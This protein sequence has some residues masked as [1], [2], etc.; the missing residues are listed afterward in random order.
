MMSESFQI[1]TR[2]QDFEAD[3]HR[4]IREFRILRLTFIESQS[5]T[6]PPCLQFPIAITN[7]IP[8]PYPNQK[9][10]TPILPYITPHLSLSYQTLLY[11]QITIRI[12][13]ADS[14]ADSK[15]QVRI[16]NRQLVAGCRFEK[17]LLLFLGCR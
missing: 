2:D 10:I 17:H 12:P 13:V 11:P 5:Q 9:Y 14:V 7:R 8:H 6:L 15:T 4:I 1:Y 3:F 16:S